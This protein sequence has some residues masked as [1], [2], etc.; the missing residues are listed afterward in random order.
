MNGATNAR[1]TVIRRL[2]MS[3]GANSGDTAETPE[4]YQPYYEKTYIEDLT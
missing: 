2:T 4:I 1:N 3:V